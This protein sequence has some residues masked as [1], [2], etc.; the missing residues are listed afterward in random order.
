MRVNLFPS[1]VSCAQTRMENC[2]SRINFY[3]I[4]K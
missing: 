3:L 4:M 1:G 2:E